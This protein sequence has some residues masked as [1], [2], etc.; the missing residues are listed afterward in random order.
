MAGI[1]AHCGI[2]DL[3]TGDLE[4]LAESLPRWPVFSDTRAILS[5]ASARYTLCICS[6][7]E[8]DLWRG[9]HE[10][11]GIPL[12]L[13][14]TAQS[15]RSYKPDPRHFRVALALLD[16]P[17]HKVLHV[18]ESRRHDIEPAKRLGFRTVWV[19]RH[20]D[21]PGPSASGQSDAVADL[22][23]ASLD[24]LAGILQLN[25]GSS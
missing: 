7:I 9:T 12:P 18:A 16:L 2:R 4:A 19:N 17:P 21:R 22:E 6:N 23:V 10:A 24:E 14:V 13:V 20:T 15:C 3:S 11:I 5:S 1:A 25:S 8:D